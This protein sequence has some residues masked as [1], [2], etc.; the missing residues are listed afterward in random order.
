MLII[1]VLSRLQLKI[2]GEDDN[3]VSYIF[4]ENDYKI[5]R[6]IVHVIET[7]FIFWSWTYIVPL[8][9]LF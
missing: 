6:V 5:Q 9:S 3:A 8:S 2:I 4:R 1:G 7:V